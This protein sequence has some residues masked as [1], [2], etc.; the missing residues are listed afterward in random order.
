MKNTAYSLPVQAHTERGHI[1][2]NDAIFESLVNYK[3]LVKGIWQCAEVNLY[4]NG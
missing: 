4:F 2:T 3:P 1:E